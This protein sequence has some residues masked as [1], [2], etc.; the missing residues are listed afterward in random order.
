M[1]AAQ[2]PLPEIEHHRK[3]VRR[4][5]RFSLAGLRTEWPLVLMLCGIVASLLLMIFDRWRRGAFA[6]GVVALLAALLRVLL[7]E[8]RIGLL[9]VRARWFDIASFT[10]AGVLI[11]W[12]SLSVD[13]LGTG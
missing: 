5:Q 6:I 2:A 3:A 10:V 7:P 9:A 11:I 4:P 1:S 8:H 13:A 12:L